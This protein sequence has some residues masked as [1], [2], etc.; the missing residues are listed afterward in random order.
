MDW[1]FVVVHGAPAE[2]LRLAKI[3]VPPGTFDPASHHVI[4]ARHEISIMRGRRRQDGKDFV[5]NFGR[6]ALVRIETE[7]PLVSAF[8][9]GAVAQVAKPVEGELNHPG[10]KAL[11]DLGGAVGAAG[12]RHY[13]FIGP[14]H[15]RDG[16]C[17]LFG[18]VEGEDIGRYFLHVPSL[19]SPTAPHAIT[20]G[21]AMQDERSE[22]RRRA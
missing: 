4:A 1:I 17:D 19:L 20:A 15:A 21:L 3:R 22:P 9:D 6:T 13:D 11:R 8:G 18:L 16:G 10:A 12:I 2:E 14:Q 5:A 7:D